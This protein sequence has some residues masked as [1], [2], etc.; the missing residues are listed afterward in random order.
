MGNMNMT[1]APG[2]GVPQGSSTSPSS[3]QTLGTGTN[4]T[5]IT[6]S[7]GGSQGG[8]PGMSVQNLGI[9]GYGFAGPGTLGLPALGAAGL[10][11]GPVVVAGAAE[12]APLIA[13]EASS[14]AAFW[15]AQ[16]PQVLNL[17]NQFGQGPGTPAFGSG[18]LGAAEVRI[19]QTGG[20][21]IRT[22]TANAL[23]E[24]AGMSLSPRDWGRAVEALK[25]Y[26]GLSHNFHGSITSTGDYLD[27]ARNLVGNLLEFIP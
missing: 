9:F 3:G 2:M 18:S 4:G 26:H 11:S 22:A 25:D 13:A 16:H 19:L 1:M 23:N 8:I 27:Q 7:H 14:I 17:A 10:F 24:A 6:E 21:T 15:A 20:N 5:G 12:A